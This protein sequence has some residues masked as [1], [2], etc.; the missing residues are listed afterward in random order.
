MTNT[1]TFP[2]LL[3]SVIHGVVITV[4]D[5]VVFN[6]PSLWAILHYPEV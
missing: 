2:A 6:G 5:R 4:A 1:Q 3:L